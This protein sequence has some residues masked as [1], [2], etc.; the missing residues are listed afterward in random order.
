MFGV[1]EEQ[2]GQIGWSKQEQKKSE[3]DEVDGMAT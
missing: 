1:S 3:V 2:V